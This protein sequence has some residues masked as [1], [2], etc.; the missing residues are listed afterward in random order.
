MNVVHLVTSGRRGGAGI[1]A[2]RL[3][4]GLVRLGVKSHM[5]SLMGSIPDGLPPTLTDS[6][7]AAVHQLTEAIWVQGNR[8]ELSNTWFTLGVEGV[9][10]ETHDLIKNA[11]VLHLHWVS[12]LLSLNDIAALISSG[13]PIVW[14]LHDQWAFTGGCHYSAGCDGYLHGCT[15]C[16]QLRV[17]NTLLP[18]AAF[19]DKARLWR[20][21]HALTLIAPSHWMGSCASRG[22]FPADT[23]IHFI[24]NGLDLATFTPASRLEGRARLGLADSTIAV[25]FVAQNAGEKRK[26][27]GLLVKAIEQ[28]LQVPGSAEDLR[29]GSL[30]FLAL[31]QSD[32]VPE[33]LPVRMLP[34]TQDE[35]ALAT[36]YAAADVF[37]SPA[38]EDN[39]PNTIAEALACGTP[40]LA[41]AV[42]GIADLISEG[43]TGRFIGPPDA[44]SLANAL[45]N[46]A[47]EADTWRGFRPA[48]R[49]YAETN[50]T[51]LDCARQVI[52]VY[53]NLPAPRLPTPLAHLNKL[54]AAL[55]Q[56]VNEL[57]RLSIREHMAAA[58]EKLASLESD[59]AKRGDV[60]LQQ[61]HR[62]QSLE[63]LIHDTEQNRDYWQKA[64][65]EAQANRDHWQ[66]VHNEAQTDRDYWQKKHEAQ[67]ESDHWKQAHQILSSNRWV[68]F[69]KKL[70]LIPETTQR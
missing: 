10:L 36:I 48:C 2:G 4:D 62:I 23:P 17:F 15:C 64:H 57:G 65:N 19:T 37:V 24:R 7:L 20:D 30:C 6:P 27:F 41:F 61:G 51:D 35:A 32:G 5:I 50:L 25:L 43:V 18:A 1:A 54:E 58:A 52:D 66:K 34:P 11:D 8:T 22:A 38:I 12:G 49:A 31:G 26:G 42:G 33:W 55:I 28:L 29:S 53:K 70:G 44:A 16:P 68:Q 45:G 46:I 59:R 39:L 67:T 40:T 56:P 69:G 9:P 14:T 63:K 47:T 21:A 60:I 3:H 13:K